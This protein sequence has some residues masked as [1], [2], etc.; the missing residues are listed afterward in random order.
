MEDPTYLRSGE[1]VGSMERA[2]EPPLRLWAWVVRRG[3][4]VTVGEG[5]DAFPKPRPLQKRSTS[6]GCSHILG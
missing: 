4:R 6:E 1:R 3:A 5:A 2:P